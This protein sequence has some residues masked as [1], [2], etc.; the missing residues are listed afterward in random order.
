MCSWCVNPNAEED[1]GTLCCSHLAEYEGLSESELNR[2]DSEQGAEMSDAG[3]VSFTYPP[4]GVW[5][6]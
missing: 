4:G 1:D 2:R 6:D 3:I 5:I